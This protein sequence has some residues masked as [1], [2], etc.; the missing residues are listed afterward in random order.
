[1]R[2]KGVDGVSRKG[3]EKYFEKW[4]HL[5]GISKFPARFSREIYQKFPDLR[6]GKKCGFQEE[7][8]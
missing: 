4:R 7:N 2:E 6:Y 5:P 3:I 1:M 8:Y